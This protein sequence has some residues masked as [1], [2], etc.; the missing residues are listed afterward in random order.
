MQYQEFL[1]QQ[2]LHD[3]MRRMTP[4]A[5]TQWYIYFGFIPQHKIDCTMPASIAIECSEHH[6]ATHPDPEARERFKAM[7]AQI[8]TLPPD[9]LVSFDL[10]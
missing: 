2:G 10:R 6:I 4:T 5:L 3:M 7:R 8:A 9:R 1:L